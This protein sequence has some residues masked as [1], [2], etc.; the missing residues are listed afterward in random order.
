MAQ[1]CV[2]Q[3]PDLQNVIKWLLFEVTKF[4]LICHVV[5]TGTTLNPEGRSGM[6]ESVMSKEA[7]E[8]I[9]INT[10]FFPRSWMRLL[11]TM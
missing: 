9:Q 5:V 6:Y 10:D 11:K 2:T 7:G 8:Q 3:I 4:G 1:L